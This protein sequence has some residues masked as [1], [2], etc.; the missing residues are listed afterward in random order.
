M[1]PECGVTP[2]W[3]CDLGF[4]SQAK[5]A[6]AEDTQTLTLHPHEGCTAPVLAPGNKRLLGPPQC[7]GEPRQA[8]GPARVAVHALLAAGISR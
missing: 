2:V 6:C 1:T 8:E 4:Q 3:P 5:E 7:V